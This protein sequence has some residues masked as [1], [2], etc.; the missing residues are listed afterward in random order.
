MEK[1]TDFKSNNKRDNIKNLIMIIAILFM[2]FYNFLIT[3]NI[4]N[5]VLI[6]FFL[7]L[8]MTLDEYANFRI[9]N[10]I[11]HKCMI[12]LY[13]FASLFFLIFYIIKTI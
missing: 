3:N 7:F 5:N 12:S 13:G 4:L 9:N 2:L 1:N 10:K 6:I 11:A 8:Y